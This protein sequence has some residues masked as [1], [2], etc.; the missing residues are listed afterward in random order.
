MLVVWIALVAVPL[1]ELIQSSA[2]LALVFER[3]TGLSPRFMSAIASVATLNGIVIQMILASRVLYGLS[4]QGQLPEIFGKINPKT[5]TPLFGTTFT[6][7]LVLL[8]ALFLPLHDLADLSARLTLL[9]FAIVNLSLARIKLRGDPPPERGFVAP[10][11][12]PWAG[13]ATCIVLL[14][15]ELA[16][17]TSV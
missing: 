15:A 7:A 17:E 6:A 14:V 3:L 11:W 9:V 1:P 5:R 16:L 8:F 2:P 4:R 10:S 13:S 12:V